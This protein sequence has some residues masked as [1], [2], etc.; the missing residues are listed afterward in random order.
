MDKW[1]SAGFKSC[2]HEGQ[3]G[4]FCRWCGYPLLRDFINL[5]WVFYIVG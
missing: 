2:K 4:T 3:V 1:V 5:E